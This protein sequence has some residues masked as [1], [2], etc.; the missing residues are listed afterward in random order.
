MNKTKQNW[1][2][3][4]GDLIYLTVFVSAFSLFLGKYNFLI[5]LF[6]HFQLQYV[7]A[8]FLLGTTS[9]FLKNFKESIIAFAYLLFV[10]FSFIYPLELFPHDLEE[11]DLFYMNAQYDNDEVDTIVD[12]I[13]ENDP[14]YVAIVESNP[15]IVSRLTEFFGEPRLDHEARFNSCAIFSKEE[16][17]SLEVIEQFTMPICIAEFE[18]FNLILVHTKIPFTPFYK[19]GNEDYFEYLKV[20]MDAYQESGQKFLVV[21]DFNATYYW[22]TFRESFK[23]YFNKNIYSWSLWKPWMLPI[24]HAFSNMKID[25]SRSKTLTS[26][27]NGLLIDLKP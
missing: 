10:F 15:K 18:D 2:K 13:V 4:I 25:V 14:E 8:L 24:D 19:A 17:I 27:H 7:F 26:D 20:Q 6:S 5:G 21:G 16:P 3:Y 12:A 9:L 22:G 23:D 11:V 1:S